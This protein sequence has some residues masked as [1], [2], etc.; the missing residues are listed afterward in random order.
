[1]STTITITL[2]TIPKRLNSKNS[3]EIFSDKLDRARKDLYAIPVATKE[4]SALKHKM[5]EEYNKFAVRLALL[6]LGI[7]L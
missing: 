2:P 5:L 7:K 6:R 1:M 4:E 3:T